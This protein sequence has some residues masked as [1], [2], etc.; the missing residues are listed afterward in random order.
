MPPLRRGLLE[1][2]SL[3]LIKEADAAHLKITPEMVVKH[4]V[5]LRDVID[6][7]LLVDAETLREDGIDPGAVKVVTIGNKSYSLPEWHLIVLSYEDLMKYPSESMYVVIS[8]ELWHQKQELGEARAGEVRA[9]KERAPADAHMDLAYEREAALAEARQGRSFGWDEWDYE[10]YLRTM[11]PA[12][13][14]EFAMG[15]GILRLPMWVTPERFKG[16]IKAMRV[17]R[18]K[19]ADVARPV[20]KRP[21]PVRRHARRSREF[22]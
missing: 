16:D 2:K 9:E 22:K 18:A 4:A 1:D 7:D 8:H 3:E 19:R 6:V 11:Y 14:Y 20:F 15:M 13:S 5:P 12:T 21:V 10:E 17:E